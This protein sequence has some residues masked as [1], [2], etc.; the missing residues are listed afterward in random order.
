MNTLFK[1]WETNRHL[2]ANYLEKYTLDQLNTTP[3]GFNNNLIW[4]IGHVIVVQQSLFYRLSNLPMNISDELYGLYKNGTKPTGNTT[5]AEVDNLKS[6]LLP[7]VEQTIK[8]FTKKK[9]VT[10]NEY[11]THTG[12]HLGSIEDAI[13]FNNYHEGLHLGSMLNIRKFI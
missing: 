13:A 5:Q 10:Y 2:H 9:F 7:L 6:L 1:V 8:D 12:F 4:N 3:Q 11:T